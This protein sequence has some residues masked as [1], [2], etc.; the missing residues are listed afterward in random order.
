MAA[1]SWILVIFFDKELLILFGAN[2]TLLTLA[3]RYL[4]PLK[5]AIPFFIFG[6]MLA[7][8]LRNDNSPVL[9]TA[10]VLIT[11]I[12]NIIGEIFFTFTLDME[13]FG[14]WLI[15]FDCARCIMTPRRYS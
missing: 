3:L 12:L 5:F 10:A 14:Q 8:F 13:I 1:V 2:E 9:A 11:D 4:T 7:A 15:W 6:Q